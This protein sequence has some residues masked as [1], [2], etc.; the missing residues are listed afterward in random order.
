MIPP[1]DRKQ[2]FSESEK[3]LDS[4]EEKRPAA[5]LYLEVRAVSSTLEKFETYIETNAGADDVEF[6]KALARKVFGK[7]NPGF[8]EKQDPETLSAI[9][10][11]ALKLVHKK[12]PDEIRVRATNPRYDA[13]G[14]ESSST[15]LEVTLSDRPFIVD[16]ICHELKRQGLDLAHLIHPIVRVKRDE[17]GT[18]LRELDDEGVPEVYELYLVERVPDE[19]LE[20]LEKRITKVLEDVKVATDDYPAMRGEVNKLCLHLAELATLHKDKSESV[21]ISECEDFLRWLELHNFVFTI[22]FVASRF[23]LTP[24][25]GFSG[26]SAPAATTS[27]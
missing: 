23:A 27:P 7:A 6:F 21:A 4:S 16:S 15:A 19:Q 22:A 1:D 3:E 24:L 8:L 14:W 5:L 20:T 26:M 9:L 11:G 13:D 25:W 17:S 12:D 2:H 18:L 10:T